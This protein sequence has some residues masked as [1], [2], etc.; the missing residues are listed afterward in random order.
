MTAVVWV[1]AFKARAWDLYEMIPGFV[2]AFAVTIGV[3]LLTEPDPEV[4]AEYDE[5]REHQDNVCRDQSRKP[6]SERAVTES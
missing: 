2:A 4:M 3:S 6:L 5:V 1:I